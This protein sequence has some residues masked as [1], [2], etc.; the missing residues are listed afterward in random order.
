MALG[1]FKDVWMEVECVGKSV[2]RMSYLPISKSL[3]NK[4]NSVSRTGFSNS[5]RR[6]D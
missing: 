4:E 3:Y 1:D 6:E 2:D 5:Y